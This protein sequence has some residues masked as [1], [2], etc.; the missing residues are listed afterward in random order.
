VIAGG[1][2]AAACVHELR[3]CTQFIVGQAIGRIPGA[4]TAETAVDAEQEHRVVH[5][6]AEVCGV[7]ELEGGNALGDAGFSRHQLAAGHRID[8][9]QGDLEARVATGHGEQRADE[10]GQAEVAFGKI[11]SAICDQQQLHRAGAQER[12]VDLGVQAPVVA[13]TFAQLQMAQVLEREGCVDG[14]H[15][16]VLG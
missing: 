14:G 9:G 3:H 12:P 8:V 15:D 1:E 16:A 5:A 13:E 2:D 10:R 11:Q 4:A 7:V 6:G